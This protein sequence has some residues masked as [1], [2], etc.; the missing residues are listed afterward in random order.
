MIAGAIVGLAFE[1]EHF[2][3]RTAQSETKSSCAALFVC[4]LFDRRRGVSGRRAFLN[5]VARGWG[6]P[7]VASP[8]PR[9]MAAQIYVNFDRYISM[10]AGTLAN[11]FEK[12]ISM[13]RSASP[14]QRKIPRPANF[15]RKFLR[16][17]I[18][19]EIARLACLVLPSGSYLRYGSSVIASAR[20]RHLARADS[21]A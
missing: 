20:G 9:N 8:R 6:T 13:D 18:F 19:R 3:R 1:H 7:K 12:S 16:R 10:N 17:R 15:L 14:K 4:C 11:L 2:I 21:V 5:F